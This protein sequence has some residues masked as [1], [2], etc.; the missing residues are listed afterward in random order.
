M[1]RLGLCPVHRGRQGSRWKVRASSREQPQQEC[2]LQASPEAALLLQPVSRSSCPPSPTTVI[3]V[4]PQLPLRGRANDASLDG[5]SSSSSTSSSIIRQGLG[6]PPGQVAFGFSRWP[7]SSA[8]SCFLCPDAIRVWA[9]LLL[10][11]CSTIWWLLALAALPV[12]EALLLG[13]Q[14]QC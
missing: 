14:C 4:L 13:R 7:R 5:G 1:G 2:L 3:S 12:S 8:D 11:R 10:G 9:G 6:G